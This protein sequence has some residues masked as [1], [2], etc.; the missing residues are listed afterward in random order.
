MYAKWRH[1][2]PPA[3]IYYADVQQ[4][5][6]YMPPFCLCCSLY[7]CVCVCASQEKKIGLTKRHMFAHDKRKNKV[8]PISLLHTIHNSRTEN[9]NFK[10]ATISTNLCPPLW[11]TIPLPVQSRA[12]ANSKLSKSKMRNKSCNLKST[13]GGF[14]KSRVEHVELAWLAAKLV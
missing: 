4:V 7:V 11:L 14:E 12:K 6:E 5:H 8:S 1:L 10:L 13:K 9:Y 2:P 3:A